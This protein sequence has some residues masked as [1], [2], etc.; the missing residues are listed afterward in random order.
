M[1]NSKFSSIRRSEG[2]LTVIFGII[3]TSTSVGLDGDRKQ[4]ARPL[5]F[6]V[7][8]D[9]SA[10]GDLPYPP[11]EDRRTETLTSTYLRVCGA[12]QSPTRPMTRRRQRP[13]T[14]T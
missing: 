9:V 7:K 13:G 4:V 5:G 12:S 2:A 8:P 1:R 14:E 3:V 11:L 6:I 10:Y